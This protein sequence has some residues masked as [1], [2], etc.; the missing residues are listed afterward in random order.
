[1]A[2]AAIGSLWASPL[3]QFFARVL[4]SSLTRQSQSLRLSPTAYTQGLLV[5]GIPSILAGI[6]ESIL[7]AVPK[8]KTSHMKK[9]H[10]Q[11]AGKA[12]Q[13]LRNVTKCP[14]CGQPK[15]PHL[16]CPTCVTGKF[17]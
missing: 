10:R 12:L 5:Y 1:M 4:P 3:P 11:L 16:L 2:M 7:R 14:G 6:W 17:M 9:R 13:D 8:K 15:R